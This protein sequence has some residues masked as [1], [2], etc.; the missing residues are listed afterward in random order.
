M[1]RK[2]IFTAALAAPLLLR[3]IPCLADG[4]YGVIKLEGAVNPIIAEH[5]VHSIV[6]AEEKNTVSLSSRWTRPA[7]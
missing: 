4:E 5:I 6:E 3:T 7:D 1:L 2:L